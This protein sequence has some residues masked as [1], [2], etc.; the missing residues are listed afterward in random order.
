M[1]TTTSAVLRRIE[2][3][4]HVLAAVP[5]HHAVDNRL[6]NRDF[7]HRKALRCQELNYAAPDG[8]WSNRRAVAEPRTAPLRSTFSNVEIKQSGR[9]SGQLTASTNS[10]EAF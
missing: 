2:I 4:V 9:I 3:V 1:S 8:A 10:V 5:R 6:R 7:V